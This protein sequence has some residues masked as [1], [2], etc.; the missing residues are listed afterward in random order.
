MIQ[1]ENVSKMFGSG[2]YG[3]TEINLS[4]E[5][6]EFVFIVG[7]TGSGKT[8]LFRLLIREM[9][10]SQGSIVVGDFDLI[11]LPHSRVS[12][13]RKK[14]GVIFQDLKLI[15]DRTVFENV[16]LPLEV[17]GVPVSEAI[18]RA[19]E[20][21]GQVELTAHRDKF[22]LQLSGGELQRTAI[23]RSLALSPEVLLADEPTGNLDPTTSREIVNLLGD[24]NKKGTTVLMATHNADIVNEFKKRVVALQK[25]RIIK[26]EKKGKYELD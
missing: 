7:P 6:G 13:L 10:P 20:L 15:V 8:T 26:D 24:I 16:L 5:K 19:E 23:A 25:G 21:L 11:K 4:I 1:L 2:A 12:H 14:I 17:V 9:L 18:K 22:P 3:L